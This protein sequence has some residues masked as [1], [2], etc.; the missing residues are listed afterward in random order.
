MQVFVRLVTDHGGVTVLRTGSFF[1]FLQVLLA[2]HDGESGTIELMRVL[3][4]RKGESMFLRSY[5]FQIV[6]S[7]V[8]FM[9]V[10][11]SSVLAGTKLVSEPSPGKIMVDGL[12]TD[13]NDIDLRYLEKSL[14]TLGITHDAENLYLMW[15]FGD[16]RLATMILARGVTVWVN[17]NAKMKETV[18][19]RYSGSVALAQTLLLPNAGHF[20]E[21]SDTDQIQGMGRRFT[22]REPGV[23]T[24]LEGMTETDFAEDHPQG[25][26]AAS[27][28]V[29]DIFCYELRIPLGLVG[30]RVAESPAD[31][32]RKLTLGI[33]IGGLSPSE[34][35]ENKAIMGQMSGGGMSGGGMGGPGAGMD[36]GGRRGGGMTGGH[37]RSGGGRMTP[38]EVVWLKIDL[39]P[40]PR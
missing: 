39:K 38:P 6:V 10:S 19:V 26:S 22:P 4:H 12:S 32:D 2:F 33:Q 25:P 30:G 15:R 36:G 34:R 40:T 20:G 13:W 5:I 28:R 29:K 8:V 3:T 1:T 7:L 35:Y 31:E 16:E 17:G 37:G 11:G 27:M 24:L 21:D 23:V 18:G 9:S 14:R